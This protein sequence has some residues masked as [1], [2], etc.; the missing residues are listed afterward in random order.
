V[1]TRFVL[2]DGRKIEQVKQAKTALLL[3]L[4]F[5]AAP[6]PAV[7]AQDICADPNNLTF[8]CQ[9]DTFDYVPPYG[10]VAS[11]WTPF[12]E[13]AVEGQLPSFESDSETPAAPA[14]L[15]WSAWLPFTAGIYQ[16][17]EVT[18][19]VA[20]IAAIGWAAYASSDDQGQRNSGLFVG[21]KVGIDP[22]GGT[23][24]TS[25]SI[26]WSPEVWDELGG[27]FP[28]L[29]VSAVAQAPVITVFVR[30]HNPQS[31]GNDKV[32][33]D[34]VPLTVDPN[35]PT[36]TPTP[37]PASAT[38]TSPPPTSTSTPLPPADTPVPT[39]TPPI[40][41][42]TP[43]PTS[44]PTATPMPTPT[45]TPTPTHTPEPTIAPVGVSTSVPTPT[46]IPARQFDWSSRIP[47]ILLGV[48]V[49]SFVGVGVLGGVLMLLRR[50]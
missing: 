1:G 3:V 13:S 28:Q 40:P 45:L 11:G 47:N 5:L 34:A 43:T 19:G 10:A 23:D 9:F 8:N 4:F 42:D 41:T 27:V 44:S 2:G 50:S 12:V 48:A 38:P 14:Q 16:Q 7:Q 31:H 37:I 18:P 29:R 21:R 22:F 35:Q 25:P 49:L 20:Y 39:D 30:A 6:V 36:V 24:Y 15:I 46:S 33:F 17:V 32:W 26:V